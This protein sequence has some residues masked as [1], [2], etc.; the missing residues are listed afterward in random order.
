MANNYVITAV[1]AIASSRSLRAHQ[2]EQF[3][4]IDIF[5]LRR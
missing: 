4:P 5:A 3:S 1:A 2:P